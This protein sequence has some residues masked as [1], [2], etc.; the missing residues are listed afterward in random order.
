[1]F[2][3]N[4]SLQ[5]KLQNSSQT[6]DKWLVFFSKKQK[7]H[8]QPGRYEK[9]KLKIINCTQNYNTFYKDGGSELRELLTVEL[10]NLA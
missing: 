3:L 7:K 4:S 1:M 2:F 8:T 6:N 10:G 9:T 5:P